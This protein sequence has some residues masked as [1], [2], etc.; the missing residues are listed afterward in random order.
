MTYVF[1]LI[2]TLSLCSFLSAVLPF[3]LF[4]F[5]RLHYSVIL[6]RDLEQ[7]YNEDGAVHEDH[8]EV[9]LKQH[10]GQGRIFH[11]PNRFFVDSAHELEFLQQW[12]DRVTV[13][14][15]A[16]PVVCSEEA[17]RENEQLEQTCQEHG[18]CQ[19][20]L[21]EHLEVPLLFLV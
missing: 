10:H 20:A 19:P 15:V 16:S 18:N 9:E 1:L 11:E 12:A 8:D 5:L 17:K 7:Y 6:V 21:L 4:L 13:W 3:T 14:F 2:L